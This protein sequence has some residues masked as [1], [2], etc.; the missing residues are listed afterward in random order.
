MIDKFWKG[1]FIYVLLQALDVAIAKATSHDE[2]LPKE[3][4]VLSMWNFFLPGQH[5]FSVEFIYGCRSVVYSLIH[6]LQTHV[7][8]EIDRSIFQYFF[9]FLIARI[10]CREILQQWVISS[11]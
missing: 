9:S 7:D 11:I 5:A 3:K 6:D 4:H 1:Y 10:K 2:A 8:S